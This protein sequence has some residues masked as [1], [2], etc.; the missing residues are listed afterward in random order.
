MSWTSAHVT[1][2]FKLCDN[3]TTIKKS[4]RDYICQY[5]AAFHCLHTVCVFIYGFKP[6]VNVWMRD[7]VRTLGACLV[8]S[9]VS[10]K[11]RV[12][13]HQ[14]VIK[15]HQTR[16]FK[17]KW[18][19]ADYSKLF[20]SLSSSVQWSIHILY[21]TDE[22]VLDSKEAVCGFVKYIRLNS[23]SLTLSSLLL[24]FSKMT[25]QTYY[26]SCFNS[27]QSSELFTL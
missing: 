7:E 4:C 15:L 9:D 2:E 5:L 17:L 1:K 12:L 11:C 27:L 23:T 3:K 10:C 6:S 25:E 14:C 20:I 22:S 16:F 21:Q 24:D 19:S 13:L 8:K 18:R 26:P